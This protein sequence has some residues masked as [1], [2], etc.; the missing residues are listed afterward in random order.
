MTIRNGHTYLRILGVIVILAGIVLVGLYTLKQNEEAETMPSIEGE[1]A[2][3]PLKSAEKVDE[4][5]C[6]K[7]LKNKAGLYLAVDSVAQD[8]LK[9]GEKATVEGNLKP[10]TDDKSIYM[11]SGTIVGK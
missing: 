5:S 1:V 2:C 6:V 11:I 3:L 4:G 9:L 10:T 8:K 7:G